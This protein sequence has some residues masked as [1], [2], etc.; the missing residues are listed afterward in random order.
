V[1]YNFGEI[2]IVTLG[3]YIWPI[4]HAKGKVVLSL[5]GLAY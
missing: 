1:G 5:F 4:L 2:T 3:L